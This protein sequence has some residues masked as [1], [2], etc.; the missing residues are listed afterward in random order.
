MK[1]ALTILGILTGCFSSLFASETRTAEE[2]IAQKEVKRVRYV[3]KTE[4]LDVI[5]LNM[6]FGDNLVISEYDKQMLKKVDVQ[7]IDLVFTDFPKGK[8]LQSLNLSR[9]RMVESLRK[10]L[11]SNE[12][13]R[14]RIIRQTGCANEGEAKTLFHGIVI[15]YK[16]VQTEE[17]KK[18]EMA[19][20]NK[21]LPHADSLG[22]LK[23]LRK[24]L[25]DS[26]ILKV[27]ERKKNWD[28]M[29]VV[30]DLTGSM[31]P[32]NSQLVLWFKL[33]PA[34]KR[35]K[36]VV[37]FNDGDMTPDGSKKIGATGGIYHTKASDYNTIRDLALKTISNGCGGD[38]PENNLEAL[39]YA[40]KKAP[41]T[42]DLVMIADNTAPVKDLALLEKLKAPVHIILCGT[43]YGVNPQYL[44]IAKKTGGTIH[45]MEKDLENLV[46]KNEGE[47][48][49]FLGEQFLVKDG[50]IIRVHPL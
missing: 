50:A 3:L 6:P 30:A 41:N 13:V 27:L 47:R 26:T 38:A 12:Q 35:I 31:A 8:D 15:H 49:E 48:F 43:A 28:N 16:P 40:L 34:D 29:T 20:L 17:D 24:N 22:D 45:T 10:N 46:L 9:I 1:T 33:K 2:I 32:Y 11:I 19:W 14:W 21:M 37:F 25:P 7:L 5:V 23:K 44:T 4:L 39:L 36:D 18:E 42:R